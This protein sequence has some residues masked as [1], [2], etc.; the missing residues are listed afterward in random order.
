MFY[1]TS[2]CW[3][4]MSVHLTSI[5]QM[6]YK[7]PSLQLISTYSSL[8]FLL[9]IVNKV[10]ICPLYLFLNQTFMSWIGNI[11][12]VYFT[13][14]A[15]INFFFCI[16]FAHPKNRKY[17]KVFSCELKKKIGS[18]HS[19]QQTGYILTWPQLAQC[20]IIRNGFL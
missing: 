16:Y 20:E 1:N 11:L 12:W 18:F 15:Q 14:A 3:Q 8:H 2:K 13:I 7:E 17:N 4:V 9:V 19:L 5:Y 10:I 6:I